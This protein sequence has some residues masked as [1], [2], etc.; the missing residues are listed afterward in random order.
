MLG[1][2]LSSLSLPTIELLPPR[3]AAPGSSLPAPT[4]NVVMLH[5]RPRTGDRLH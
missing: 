5:S 1:D 3:E 4:S 2:S